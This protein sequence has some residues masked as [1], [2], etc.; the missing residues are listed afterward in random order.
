MIDEETPV[1]VGDL[2]LVPPAL[3][4]WGGMWLITG[5][6]WGMWICVGVAGISGAVLAIG[7]AK[8]SDRVRLQVMVLGVMMVSC[9]VVGGLRVWSS[10]HGPL[11]EAA[12]KTA[13]VEVDVV[14]QN[15]RL[16]PTWG[17]AVVNATCHSGTI[18]GQT[19]KIRQP[20]VLFVPTSYTEQ[21]LG[22][23]AG[24]LISVTVKLG[25]ADRSDLASVTMSVLGEAQIIRPPP[26]W[27]SV[28]ESMRSGLRNAM[29]RSPSEHAS[30]VP[31]LVVGDTS[32]MPVSLTDDFRKTGLTHLT[33]VSGANL[34]IMLSFLSV[35]ARYMG[36]RGRWLTVISVVGVAVFIALCHSEP[37]VLRASAMG[38]V[39]LAA[40][41]RGSGRG[42]GLAS[43]SLAVIGLCWID[44][45]MSRSMGFILSILACLG[46]IV[47]GRRWSQVLERWLPG[48]VA[49]AM[50][51]P[52]AAQ[53]ATQPV[54]C[55]LSGA[56]SV[57]GILANAAAGPWVAPATVLGFVAALISPVSPVIAS[58][59]GYVAGWCAQPI[60]IVGHNLASLPGASYP[61][62][63]TIVAMVIIVA[64]CVVMAWVMPTLLGR[65]W[66]VLLATSI[67]VSLMVLPPY[68]PGW[69][70]HN[71]TVAMC[72]VGQGDALAV[73]TGEGEAIVFDVGPEGESITTC[74]QQLGI[75]Q[76]SL[77]VLTHFHAD[78]SGGFEEV[79]SSIPI[80]ALLVPRGGGY[81]AEVLERAAAKGIPISIGEKGTMGQVGEARIAILSAWQSVL[82]S[83]VQGESATE[84][85]ESLVVRV[86][87]DSMSLLITGDIENLGQQAAMT[88]LEALKVD[89]LKV[90]HHGSA[91]HETE[92]LEAT[93]ARIAVIGVGK[94][95]SYGHPAPSTVSTLV[96]AGM[97]VI[98]TDEHGSITISR[99]EQWVITTQR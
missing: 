15:A 77:L 8:L 19:F 94:G 30:L 93:Q 50:A 76:I 70:G 68:Q 78:H 57:A 69:P 98:R 61:W 52:L 10:G 90:P 95:N 85:D 42:A 18:A 60:L 79:I 59:A 55:W 21:W 4:V 5:W 3:A 58:W 45:W 28:I 40:V 34:A 23:P 27:Q 81:S 11:V 47:W 26:V 12:E 87:T 99:E 49:E 71:W 14:I 32:T 31:A 9:L 73:R 51:I 53:I 29:Y 20:V 13:V 25:S 72:D 48:W 24:S 91:R 2:R 7:K 33:A 43:L 96:N 16:S 37:S 66:V 84:N 62:P 97:E 82:P 22:L 46:I 67:M 74:I 80:K 56:V 89:I 65:A 75:R 38:I 86:D 17:M 83:T 63:T 41:G 6:E 88:D 54:I 36:V 92:F 39:T 64:A 44:P 1:S 35:I